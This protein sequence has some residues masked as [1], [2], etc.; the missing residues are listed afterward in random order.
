[1]VADLAQPLAVRE[2]IGL[3]LH[4]GEFGCYEKTPQAIRLVP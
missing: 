4:C 1:M 3:A 2:R